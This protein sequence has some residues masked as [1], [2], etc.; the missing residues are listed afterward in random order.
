MPVSGSANPNEPPTPGVPNAFSEEPNTNVGK[1]F[2]KPSEN[3][4]SICNTLSRKP[5]VGGVGG[6]VRA[7]RVG[8]V[9]PSSEPPV[10]TEPYSLATVLSGPTPT[11]PRRRLGIGPIL[12]PA[13]LPRSVGF[14]DADDQTL[15]AQPLPDRPAT[16]T[17]YWGR[18]AVLC[19][20]RRARRVWSPPANSAKTIP[21][22]RPLPLP[23]HGGEDE[24]MPG[25]RVIHDGTSRAWTAHNWPPISIPAQTG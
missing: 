18:Q 5:S 16:L 14:V 12:D 24:H 17:N 10:A 23:P 6:L 1:G 3:A 9:M 19:E 7:S 8:V 20:G 2:V 11:D 13:V 4:V 15:L 25:G 22:Q 21:R